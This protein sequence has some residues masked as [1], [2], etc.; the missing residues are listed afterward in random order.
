LNKSGVNAIAGDL[1]VTGGTVKLVQANQIASGKNLALSSGI[2]DLQSNN[3]TLAGVQ[4]TGGSINGTGTLTAGTYDLQSGTVTG[5]LGAGTLNSSGTVALNGTAGAGTVNVTAGTL[6]LGASERLSNSA[7]LNVSG[8]TLAMGGYDDAVGAVS[9]TSGS[10]TGTGGT[11]TGSSYAM[12]SGTVSAKLGGTG[13]LTKTTGGT[14]TLSGV[15]SYTGNTTVAAGTLALVGSGSIANSAEILAGNTDASSAVL[16]VSAVTGG[17]TL[18]ST[19]TLG[20]TGS[21]TGAVTISAGGIL[22]P[23]ASIE[24]LTMDALTMANGAIFKYEYNA[25]LGADVAADL[26]TVEGNLSLGGAGGTVTLNLLEL[27]NT[28]FAE[29]T[30]LSL[31]QYTGTLDGGFF[32]GGNT[33]ADGDTVTLDNN[34]WTIHYGTEPGG[35]NFASEAIAGSLFITL[36]NFSAIPE[37]GSLLALGCLV[38]SGLMLRRRRNGSGAL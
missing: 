4:L 6:T 23:G 30:T 12:Q 11:L 34:T 9:L 5:N 16:D 13:A 38:G 15:N 1:T 18:G 33:L 31:I 22:S 7:A 32:Y 10:I 8:G 36:D 19:Q 29:N 14:L 37:P 2:F 3:Q 26:L 35:L 27:T 17:F 28:T 20:G 25:L 24:S 21:I